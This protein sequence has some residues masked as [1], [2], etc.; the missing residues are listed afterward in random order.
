MFPNVFSGQVHCFFRF[1]LVAF[2]EAIKVLKNTINNES[3]ID[4]YKDLLL[5][6]INGE[7]YQLLSSN[8][9]RNNIAHYQLR[10]YD[11]QTFINENS[12]VS[13]IEFETQENISSFYDNF[14]NEFKMVKRLLN[15]ILFN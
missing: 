11:P 10:G 1:K 3:E 15:E 7:V 6:I 5:K 13:I 4:I 9:I 14:E 8:R 12:I 2:L